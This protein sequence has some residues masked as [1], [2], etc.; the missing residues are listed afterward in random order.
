MADENM[1]E[2]SEAVYKVG[3]ISA[4]LNADAGRN[5]E[6]STTDGLTNLFET[7]GD[8]SIAFVREV[9]P[10][11]VGEKKKGLGG[12]KKQN[13]DDEKASGVVTGV[14]RKITDAGTS[15][16]EPSR[17][18]QRENKKKFKTEDGTVKGD[19]P[20]RL[21]RTIFVGNIPISATRK[22]L[23]K[24]FT[25]YGEVEN[26]RLRSVPIANAKH[27]R[28]LAIVKKELHPER[29]NMNA[30]VVFKDKENAEKALESKGAE[31][32]GLHIRVDIA[33]HK[34][35]DN[36]LS[37]FI[38]NLPFNVQEEE[39]REL[40][41]QCGEVDD[42]RLIRDKSSGIGKGFGYVRFK[43]KESVMF[44]MKMKNSELRDRKI[45]VFAAVNKIDTKKPFN[46]KKDREFRMRNVSSTSKG[47]KTGK[48]GKWEG[49]KTGGHSKGKSKFVTAK[50]NKTKGGT[51][52]F[53]S[54]G[55]KK[56][57]K[58]RT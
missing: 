40:F 49:K 21:S 50:N 58:K 56:V 36:K 19:D 9:K 3:G 26:V 6:K 43:N 15:S 42:V 44:A 47:D 5:A 8:T 55:G 46:K 51:K 22:D 4:S 38:G 39:I 12:P 16:S 35:M 17:K 27:S 52:N 7:K 29:N 33:G 30:Y 45:R 41:S 37:V 34:E 10:S 18:K 24:F 2:F 57:F 48:K 32:K 13:V 54:K 28:K 25:K 1:A 23:K 14:K 53:A 20:E 11:N 31:F